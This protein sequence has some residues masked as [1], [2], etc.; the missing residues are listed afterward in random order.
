MGRSFGGNERVIVWETPRPRTRK[1]L[2][3]ASDL[4]NIEF[5]LIL[6]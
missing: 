3:T 5:K 6:D 2:G 1:C 4:G